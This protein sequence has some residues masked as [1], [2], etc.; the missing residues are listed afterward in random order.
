MYSKSL[1][2]LWRCVNAILA[3]GDWLHSGS[4]TKII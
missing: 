1:A 4:P 3:H 2:S